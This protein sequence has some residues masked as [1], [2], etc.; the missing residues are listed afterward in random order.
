MSYPPGTLTVA[1]YP[2]AQFYLW[3]WLNVHKQ[4]YSLVH[5]L[6]FVCL[7]LHQNLT[8][9]SAN[10]NLNRAKRNECMPK[11]TKLMGGESCQNSTI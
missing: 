6:T 1:S 11:Y 10:N 3:A 9:Y 5:E 2:T 8:L 4:K 7:P